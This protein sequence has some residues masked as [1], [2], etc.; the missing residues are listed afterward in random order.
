[1]SGSAAERTVGFVGLGNMGGRMA[2]RLVAAGVRVTGYDLRPGQAESA[3]A[4]QAASLGEVCH[5]TSAVLLSLPDSRAVEAVV[6]GSR[7][8]ADGLLAFARPGQVLIDLSTSA[9]SSTRRLHDLLASRGIAYLDAGISG[10]AVAA[11]KGTLTIMAGGSPADLESV[12]WVFEPIAAK[13]VYLGASGAGHSVKL[14]NNFLNTVTLAATAEVMVAAR[15]S[16]LDLAAVLDVINSSSGVS[17]ASLNRFPHIIRGD[18]LE[19]GL[20]SNLMTKDVVA[21]VD[22]VRELGVPCLNAAG[23]LASFGAAANLGYGEQIS[24]RVVYAIGDLAGGI[25]LFAADGAGEKE[26]AS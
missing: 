15:A 14:L 21:Y 7:P 18:Y 9:P 8:S 22:H 4:T 2:R 26:D 16:G 6:L 11:E 19:G 25:R 20:T 23:P 5:D 17:F 1:V 13:V 24:N 10:G 3:G 12:R